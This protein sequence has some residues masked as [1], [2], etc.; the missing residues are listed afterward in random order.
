MNFRDTVLAAIRRDPDLIPKMTDALRGRIDEEQG[1]MSTVVQAAEAIEPILSDAVRRKPSRLGKLGL[2][3]AALLATLAAEDESS[4]TLMN[5]MADGHPIGIVF[6][7]I[8]G[9]TA[10]TAER[11]D[12]EA[13]KLLFEVEDLIE[14]KIKPAKGKV[15]KNLGDGF[16]LAFPSASQA[17]RAAISIRDGMARKRKQGFETTLRI[18][19]HAGEPLVEGDD[20][21]GFDV[22]LT[23]RLL[24]FCKPSQ[25]VVSQAAKEL[26]EGRLQKVEFGRSRAVK[27][28]GLSGRVR[29]HAVNPSSNGES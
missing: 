8:A 29:I 28:R 24:D 4:S 19:V 18:A 22:N 16:L 1:P 11:G 21:L 27:I 10:F 26:S 9:F 12:T 6:V 13:R 7:D 17:V 5:A 25:V 2:K 14:A 15:V 20:L 3:S 23:A